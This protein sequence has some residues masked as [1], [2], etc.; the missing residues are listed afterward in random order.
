MFALVA[1][2]CGAVA[3][4]QNENDLLEALKKGKTTTPPP[5]EQQL[6][7]DDTEEA[8]VDSKQ[9]KVAETEVGI[10]APDSVVVSD[11]SDAL[12]V[13]DS[14]ALIL[15]DA[16]ATKRP[17]DSLSIAMDSML[18]A[19]A[20]KHSFMAR[21]VVIGEPPMVDS[22]DMAPSDIPDSVYVNRLMAIGSA[23]PMSYNNVVRQFIISYTTRNKQVISNALGR[24]LYYFP[25]FEA[26]LD[27][28]G[29]PLELRMLPVIESALIPKARSKAGAA[30][31]WQF[32]YGTSKGYGL[33]VSSFIDQRF[34]PILS[35]KAACKFLKHLYNSYGDWLLALAA[36]NC[37]PGNVNKALRRA[38]GGKTF[39]DIYP[40]LPR[41][42]RSYVPA[43]IAT[44]Y[45][46]H[47][48][49]QHD[50]KPIAPPVPLA[51]DTLRIDR[52]MHLEQISSTIC[53][54][55]DV[56]RALSP[57][58]KQ[59][60]L[61]AVRGRAYSLVLPITEVGKFID[62]QSAIMGKDTIYLAEYMSPVKNGE[63]PTFV[64]DSKTHIVKSGENLSIIAKK[65]NV[66]VK[67]LIKWNNIKN[68]S[69]LRV[70]QK[71]EVF[72]K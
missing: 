28:Q 18:C 67:Q 68:P 39:W 3:Q 19:W 59:D 38:D 50:I 26:E 45:T 66:T 65:Y 16:R 62:N 21:E 61:P 7:G 44:T 41:E 60:I 46:Y 64:I 58:F 70:G 5:T 35:T 15:A 63:I 14:A 10:M 55:I 53:T 12:M 34:D 40:Y 69:K 25:L 54:P 29:L 27:A 72:F 17:T 49:Q 30:G 47:Y 56:L 48:H 4:T 22:V 13:A 2:V 8:E 51:V 36:Y 9:A 52:I 24:S 33:E 31:L 57:Q 1:V 6:Y 11:G 23:I 37:G 43:F 71:L 20:E 32:M 42:T